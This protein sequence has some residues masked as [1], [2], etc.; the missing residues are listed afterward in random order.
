M[1]KLLIIALLVWGCDYAPTEHTHEN[2]I[3]PL[4]GK[5]ALISHELYN[6]SVDVPDYW[7]LND[8]SSYTVGGMHSVW[9]STYLNYYRSLEFNSDGTHVYEFSLDTA[10]GDT[11]YFEGIWLANGNKLTTIFDETGSNDNYMADYEITNNEL[12][13][14][15]IDSDLEYD[16]GYYREYN[17]KSINTFRKV[18]TSP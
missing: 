14:T 10:I 11:I 8:S 9:D 5:W 7:I 2:E 17:Y 18:T 16:D 13:T 6:P 15:V 4:V 12:K 1:K 3:H